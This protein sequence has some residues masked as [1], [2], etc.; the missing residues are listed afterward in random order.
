LNLQLP[1]T[2]R[3]V[4]RV[5]ANNL[6]GTGS[7]NVGLFCRNPTVPVVANL[8]C[9]D[10]VSSTISAP[11]EVDYLTFDGTSG[12]VI[13]LTMVRTS[14]FSGTNAYLYLFS[15]SNALLGQFQANSWLNLALPET[16]PYVVRVIANDLVGTGNYNV[17]L[18]CRNPTVPVVANLN[19]GDIVSSTISTP[20]EVDYFTFDGT[21]GD[22]IDLTLVRTSGFSG[23]NVYV[24]LFSPSN[25]LI[26]GFSANATRTHVLP[27]TGPYVC[28]VIASNLVGTGG[29]DLGLACP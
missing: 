27:E 15:P 17:G 25:L 11:G 22:T 23:T 5:I 26:D 9:G 28:R 7:Y 2:G 6:L 29:Y 19:C 18:F 24:Y 12:D 20:G 10:I 21:S 4:V 1:Q 3:Y 13:D 14:G 16:G 8:T